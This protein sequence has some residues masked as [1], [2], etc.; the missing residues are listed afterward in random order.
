MKFN[1]YDT[2]SKVIYLDKKRDKKM[3]LIFKENPRCVYYYSLEILKGRWIEGEPALFDKQRESYDKKYAL[4]YIK[5]VVKER[6]SD[7]E[8]IIVQDISLKDAYI[9]MLK[10]KAS[11]Q[12]YAEFLLFS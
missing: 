3:E 7:Y 6:I 1:I 2:L 9:N 5:N 10:K 8:E 11:K 4:M 12:D